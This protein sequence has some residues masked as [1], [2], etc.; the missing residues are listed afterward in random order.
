MSN[1]FLISDTHFGHRN[2]VNFESRI[3]EGEKLRPLW[4]TVEE[5]NEDLI[6]RWN[7]VVRPSDLV[8][9]LGDFYSSSKKNIHIA[10]R[11]NGR[12]KLVMGNHEHGKA[13]DYLIY[14]ED[15]MGYKELDRHILTHIP[16][17]E[18]QKYRFRANIHGHLHEHN[19]DDPWY[20]NVSCEQID[21]T[22][23][24][25]EEVRVKN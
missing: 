20:I 21:Y 6:S 16:V 18:S 3:R 8:Y 11:L 12:K 17:H 24:A 1:T 13:K 2:I 14:F 23:I 9:H 25:W 10:G 4:D 7:S 5:M 22:P 15:V 19:I